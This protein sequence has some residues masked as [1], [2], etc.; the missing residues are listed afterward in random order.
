VAKAKSITAMQK[1]KAA[2]NVDKK[3]EANEPADAEVYIFFLAVAVVLGAFFHPLRVANNGCRRMLALGK[4]I[5][6]RSGHQSSNRHRAFFL[7]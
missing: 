3:H 6:R 5:T 4:S 2:K 7:K 1:R